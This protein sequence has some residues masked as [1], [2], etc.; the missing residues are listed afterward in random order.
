MTKIIKSVTSSDGLKLYADS[1]GNVGKTALVFV[2]GFRYSGAVFDPVFE[3]PVFSSKFHLVRYD[4]RGQ[5]R[6]GHPDTP[7]GHISKSYADDF[8]AVC[9]AFEVKRPYHVGW[10]YGCSVTS[11]IAA[12]LPSDYL[13]GSIFLCGPTFLGSKL[14][15]FLLPECAEVLPRLIDDKLTATEYEDALLKFL[16]M[17]FTNVTEVST[18]TRFYWR[19]MMS[20]APPISYRYLL[21][22]D[23]DTGPLYALGE[24]GYPLHYI[25]GTDEQTFNG[26]KLAGE[27]EKY[28]KNFSVLYIPKGGHS[29]FLQNTQTVIDSITV[30]VSDNCWRGAME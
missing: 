22:R 1:N 17:M 9:D 20:S 10:S 5:G 8:A 29:E 21:M 27:V 3:D 6:S 26:P 15:D 28:F 14:Y 4:L 24:K 7:E 30:F 23:V 2:H 13:S 18:E 19:G 25:I 16:N 12:N 11:D